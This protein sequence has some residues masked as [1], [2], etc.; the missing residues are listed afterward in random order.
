MGNQNPLGEVPGHQEEN[1]Q[2]L[3]A[4]WRRQVGRLKRSPSASVTEQSK[5]VRSSKEPRPIRED[6]GNLLP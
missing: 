1:Q 2:E 6:Q 3:E 5:A 4:W